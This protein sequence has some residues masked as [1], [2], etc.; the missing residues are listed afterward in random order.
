V[1]A[2]LHRIGRKFR[3]RSRFKSSVIGPHVEP[4]KI[5]RSA[6]G[7]LYLAV[8]VQQIGWVAQFSLAKNHTADESPRSGLPGGQ[9]RRSAWRLRHREAAWSDACPR[10]PT[11]LD[12]IRRA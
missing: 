12:L 4:L 3:T 10:R 2:H 1:L 7:S 9:P 5:A 11:T 8:D 6:D